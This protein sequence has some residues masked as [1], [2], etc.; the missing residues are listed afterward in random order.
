MDWTQIGIVGAGVAF[1]AWSNRDKL[2]GLLGGVLPTAKPADETTNRVM[3]ALQLRAACEKACPEAIKH[4]D[5]AIPH[6][7][8]GHVEAAK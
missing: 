3:L 6:L 5:Q 4:I 7:L 2:K 1:L 8:P